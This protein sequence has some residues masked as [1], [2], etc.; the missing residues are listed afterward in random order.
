MADV[1]GALAIAQKLANAYAM[2]CYAVQIVCKVDNGDELTK[3]DVEDLRSYLS[4]I[5]DELEHVAVALMSH[6]L[7]EVS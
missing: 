7:L 5:A 2:T 4:D 1:E 3:K 6:T